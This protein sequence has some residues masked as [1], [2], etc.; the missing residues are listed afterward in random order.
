M[1]INGCH[2][3]ERL[4]RRSNLDGI[5]RDDPRIESLGAEHRIGHIRAAQQNWSGQG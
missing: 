5:G 3:E 4:A 1:T 2:C